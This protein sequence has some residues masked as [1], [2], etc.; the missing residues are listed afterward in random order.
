MNYPGSVAMTATQMLLDWFNVSD[1]PSQHHDDFANLIASE[2]ADA[3]S[4]VIAL[5]DQLTKT[6]AG[7]AAMAKAGEKYTQYLMTTEQREKLA[8]Q[9]TLIAQQAQ[10]LTNLL[11]QTPGVPTSQAPVTQPVTAP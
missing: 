5:F 4:L 6:E 11:K 1:K 9:A 8:A 2:G 7:K 10:A 3:E